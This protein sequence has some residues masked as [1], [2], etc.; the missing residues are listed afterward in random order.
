MPVAGYTGQ[1]D[2]NVA[3][4][5]KLKHAEERY[6]RILDEITG[7][8]KPED[9]NKPEADRRSQFD[10]RCISLAKTKMQEA[11][12]WAVRSIFQP[13]RIKLPEDAA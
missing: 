8:R 4:A 7:I 5:N 12:M 10:G 1:S 3:L 2:E 9:A 11:N 6:L 13:T